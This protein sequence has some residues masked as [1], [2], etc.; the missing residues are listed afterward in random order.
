MKTNRNDKRSEL[1]SPEEIK[2]QDEMSNLKKAIRLFIVLDESFSDIKYIPFN[3]S[4]IDSMIDEMYG[5]KRIEEMGKEEKIIINAREKALLGAK[6]E[7]S[8]EYYPVEVF[9]EKQCKKE[10]ESDQTFDIKVFAECEKE[11]IEGILVQV[12][13]LSDKLYY[14]KED[15]FKQAIKYIDYLNGF[16]SGQTVEGSKTFKICDPS[17]P[18]NAIREGLIKG[19]IINNIS[20]KDF[21]YLFTEQPILKGMKRIEWKSF[22]AEAKY[23]LNRMVGKEFSNPIGNKCFVLAKDQNN[24]I[25][26]SNVK[27]ATSY[28]VIDNIFRQIK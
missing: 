7:T 26:D 8:R 28:P 3:K 23:L 1:Y 10:K 17:L 15:T 11:R 22:K 19:K 5:G 9:F 12:K 4:V 24:E 6:F 13:Q 2:Q 27:P 21:T 16:I 14:T 25:F 20:E 18:L